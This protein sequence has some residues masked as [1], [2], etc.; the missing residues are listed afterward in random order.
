MLIQ[1]IHIQMQEEAKSHVAKSII[2]LIFSQQT[3]IICHL[4]IHISVF[5]NFPTWSSVPRICVSNEGGL[6][7]L[8]GCTRPN[9]AFVQVHLGKRYHMRSKSGICVGD[10]GYSCGLNVLC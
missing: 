3:K 2:S 7:I 9:N 5:S 8:L 4:L 10:I 6:N 1:D